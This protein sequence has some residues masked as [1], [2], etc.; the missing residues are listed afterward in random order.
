MIA[1][2]SALSISSLVC[3][4]IFPFCDAL[5]HYRDFFS[6][7]LFKCAV[8]HTF[9][10]YFSSPLRVSLRFWFCL[11]LAGCKGKW[12]APASWGFCLN[13]LRLILWLHSA[14]AWRRVGGFDRCFA[15]A[16][17]FAFQSPA[18]TFFTFLVTFQI[19]RSPTPSVNAESY[20]FSL[21]SASMFP[22]VSSRQDL[23]R[24]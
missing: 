20:F 23:V 10:F 9:G 24:E 8:H 11:P 12:K 1:T 5:A 6:M 18:K 16:D 15:V 19:L 4:E 22:C 3:I 13:P 17:A 2:G 14:S 7:L 21:A